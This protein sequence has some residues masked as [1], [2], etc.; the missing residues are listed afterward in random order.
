MY[1]HLETEPLKTLSVEDEL[2]RVGPNPI[3]LVS[4]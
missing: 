4:L 1:P 3:C 2:I